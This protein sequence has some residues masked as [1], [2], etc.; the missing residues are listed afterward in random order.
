[1]ADHLKMDPARIAR[2]RDPARLTVVD[3]DVALGLAAPVGEGPLVDVGAGVG[4][5]TLPMARRFPGREALGV[6]VLPGMLALLEEAAAAEGLDAVRT[7]LMPGPTTLPLGD[8]DASLIV[9]LQVH[10]ELDDAAGLMRDCARALASGAPIVIVDWKAEDLPGMPKGGRRVPA[11]EIVRDLEGA[12]FRDVA[13]HDV[14]PQHAV[15]IGAAP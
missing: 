2:L 3:P 5:V 11:A 14:Y 4:F 10:H 6:D 1:M 8:G 7:A 13:L 9:M 12:G 15:A